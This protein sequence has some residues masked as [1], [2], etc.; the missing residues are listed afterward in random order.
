MT[1]VLSGTNNH[2]VLTLS[3]GRPTA[4]SFRAHLPIASQPIFTQSSHSKPQSACAN[5]APSTN[6]KRLTF[7]LPTGNFTP[8]HDD[9]LLYNECGFRR[10]RR[11][12]DDWAELDPY[13]TGTAVNFSESQEPFRVHLPT[14]DKI[15]ASHFT[16]R[17]TYSLKEAEAEGAVQKR[18]YQKRTGTF[19]NS[20]LSPYAWMV[21]LAIPNGYRTRQ[22]YVT[23]FLGVKNA[24]Y[25]YSFNSLVTDAGMEIAMGALIPQAFKFV[26]SPK[27]AMVPKVGHKISLYLPP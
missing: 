19:M 22:A 25:S 3:P 10:Q 15:E 9:W 17:L 18:C 4:S 24:L 5:T 7:S 11:K 14:P 1:R 12:C 13:E 6:L 21:R 26:G 16:L 27:I 2:K 8:R 20:V 23:S